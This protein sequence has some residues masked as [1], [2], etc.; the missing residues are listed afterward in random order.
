MKNTGLLNVLDTL[1]SR[2]PNGSITLECAIDN[3]DMWVWMFSVTN[4]KNGNI[5]KATCKIWDE[6]LGTPDEDGARVL[7][8][9][10]WESI[11]ET[12]ELVK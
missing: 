8:S 10:I 6:T 12:I 11:L 2:V 5:L 4:V 9:E 7:E 1:R 3:S